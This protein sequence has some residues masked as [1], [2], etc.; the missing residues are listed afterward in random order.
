MDSERQGRERHGGSASKDPGKAFG[1]DD[2]PQQGE[3]GDYGPAN[4][5]SKQQLRHEVSNPGGPPSST[6]SVVVSCLLARCEAGSAQKVPTA[7]WDTHVMGARV[8]TPPI[9]HEALL[10]AT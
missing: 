1:P 8:R 3:R 9:R 2:I 4:Q 5:E 7:N 6:V 10:C